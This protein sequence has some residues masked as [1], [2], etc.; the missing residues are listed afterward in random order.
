MSPRP[1]NR[2]S[3]DSAVWPCRNSR[4]GRGLALRRPA[5]R[6][7]C[8]PVAAVAEADSE[9]GLIGPDQDPAAFLAPQHL[10][11]GG[12][13]D[14]VE[15]HGVERQMAALALAAAQR[16]RA[17][18]AVLRAQPFVQVD[19]VSGLLRD[20]HRAAVGRLAGLLGQLGQRDVAARRDGLE[21]VGDAG[22]LGGRPP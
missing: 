20:D 17:D 4:R 21:V 3:T 10:V 8:P 19:Q 11:S 16:R 6:L 22:P 2:R 15:V 1:A 7:A 5:S 13:A 18:A 12:G 14:R 9:P